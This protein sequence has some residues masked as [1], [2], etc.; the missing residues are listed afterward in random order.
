MICIYI[1]YIYIYSNIHMST[2]NI[3]YRDIYHY[4]SFMSTYARPKIS[5]WT[6]R[7]PWT[8]FVQDSTQPT[9]PVSV[10]RCYA[11]P[12]RSRTMLRCAM[13]TCLISIY[14]CILPYIYI[15]I[16]IYTCMYTY[17]YT[18]SVL[19]SPYLKVVESYIHIYI[20]VYIYI[21]VCIYLC[22][23]TYIWFMWFD[24]FIMIYLYN[25]QW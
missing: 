17:M 6:S 25:H 21:C 18:G 15:H 11:T 20:Y 19:S 2:S 12:R 9:P 5:L 23:Y 8:F 1:I 13:W 16:Y 4:I 7:N 3:K 14:M 10:S 22:T 24:G